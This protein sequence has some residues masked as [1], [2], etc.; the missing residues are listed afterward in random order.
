MAY[1]A[2]ELN[3]EKEHQFKNSKNYHKGFIKSSYS[4]Q[5]PAAWCSKPKKTRAI[6]SPTLQPGWIQ[7]HFPLSSLFSKC[8]L[9]ALALLS[10]FHLMEPWPRSKLSLTSLPKRL[11]CPFTFFS[12]TPSQSVSSHTDFYNNVNPLKCISSLTWFLA[13][14]WALTL[15][16]A[17]PTFSASKRG[18]R[19]HNI[20]ENTKFK[21]KFKI[22]WSA[23]W[24]NV[25]DL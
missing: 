22:S 25:S 10:V 2:E 4:T 17:T 20:P 16:L 19:Y 24:T 13:K 11:N 14:S 9:V 15:S 5:F 12:P 1:H 18:M 21:I 6:Q 3:R 23:A 7:V 8:H